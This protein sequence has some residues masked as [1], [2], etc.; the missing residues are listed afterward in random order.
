MKQNYDDATIDLMDLWRLFCSKWWVMLL[1]AIVTVSGM[2]GVLKLTFVPEYTSTATLYILKQQNE[3]KSDSSV[4]SD[5]SLALNVVND[6][7]YLIKSHAVL[8]QVIDDLQLDISYTALYNSITTSNPTDT[9][10]LEVSVTAGSPQEA[11]RIA[12][13]LC[14][15]SVEQIEEAMGFQQVNF[16]EYAILNETPSNTTPLKTYFMAAVIAAIIVYALYL[17]RFLLDG[18]MRT[19]EDIKKYLGLTVLGDIPN[20]EKAN[21]KRGGHYAYNYYSK[22]A[23]QAQEEGN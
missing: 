3:Q 9:R 22:R 23:S 12:D 7:T 6:C 13:R 17:A 5:F 20:V 10:I 18:R 1:A 16:Y 2:W 14:E 8:D 15:I 11:K 19:E 21:G 4:A